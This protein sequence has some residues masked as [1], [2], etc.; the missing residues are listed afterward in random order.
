MN[1]QMQAANTPFQFTPE[2][3]AQLQHII[4]H[5]P[6]GRAQSAVIAALDLAQRQHQGWLSREA[7]E[8]VAKQLAMSEIRVYEIASFYT[9]FNLQPVGQYHLQVCTTTPCWLRGSDDVLTIC[10][11]KRQQYG[12]I[13]FTVTEVECLGACVDAPILQIN[14][15]YYENLGEQTT[16]KLLDELAQNVHKK[17]N[18]S[19][20]Q[21]ST[22]MDKESEHPA[23]PTV[24]TRTKKAVKI[25]PA[26]VKP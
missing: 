3:Q 25:K 11:Q 2:N 13:M 15:D 6:D 17:M 20:T 8:E 19:S 16:A 10:Q 9:M 18:D 22:T 12:D 21:S 23:T 5:Y 1:R 4:A 24:K 7:I 14:D 26:E